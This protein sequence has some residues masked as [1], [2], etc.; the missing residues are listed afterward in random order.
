MLNTIIS[1]GLLALVSAT[2]F[3]KPSSTDVTHSPDESL[4]KLYKQ[5]ASTE[6]PKKITE[7]LTLITA[8]VEMDGLRI[9]RVYQ[10]NNV[11]IDKLTANEAQTLSA[12]AT[13]SLASQCDEQHELIE[14]GIT[15][16]H[17]FRDKN[18]RMISVVDIEKNRCDYFKALSQ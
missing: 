4:Q 6:T 2:V 5:V 11:D 18:N 15:F 8:E 1:V 14:K 7:T 16:R 13:A 3:A 12:K 10:Y 17:L 9:R